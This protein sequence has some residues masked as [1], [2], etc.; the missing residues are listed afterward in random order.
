MKKERMN[1]SHFRFI[2]FNLKI[3]GDIVTIHLKTVNGKYSMAIDI[4]AL[5]S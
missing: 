3:F 5:S 2:L 1:I 4:R